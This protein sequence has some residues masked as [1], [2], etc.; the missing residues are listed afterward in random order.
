MKRTTERPFVSAALTTF[1]VAAQPASATTGLSSLEGLFE[2]LMLALAVGLIGIL[3]VAYFVY[4]V[5]KQPQSERSENVSFRTLLITVLIVSAPVVIWLF[6]APGLSP[7]HLWSLCIFLTSLGLALWEFSGNSKLAVGVVGAFIV[8]YCL[9]VPQIISYTQYA[10]IDN[11]VIAA[12]HTL[13][14]PHGSPYLHTTS[15]EVFRLARSDYSSYRKIEQGNPLQILHSARDEGNAIVTATTTALSIDFHKHRNRYIKPLLTVPLRREQIPLNEPYELGVVELVDDANFEADSRTLSMALGDTC[16]DAGWIRRLVAHG[17]DAKAAG[18]ASRNAI[19]RLA[20]NI[21][22]YEQV[23]EACRIMI[24]AGV[25]INAMDDW[26]NT[27][28]YLTISEASHRVFEDPEA[29][30]KYLEFVTLLLESGAD[31]NLAKKNAITPLRMAIVRRRYELAE[32]L[33]KYGAD[34][35]IPDAHDYTAFQAAERKLRNS[36]DAQQTKVL[37]ALLDRMRQQQH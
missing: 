6:A 30:A 2:A 8:A 15:G 11:N 5:L 12:T 13:G 24:D 32:L 22:S 27:P 23:V 20:A 37:T 25:D 1:A 7:V 9:R 26:G 19:H 33:V 17:A 14:P 3:V 35:H 16:C 31:P 10:M 4:Q 18:L 36:E 34:P 29:A 28:L 21:R